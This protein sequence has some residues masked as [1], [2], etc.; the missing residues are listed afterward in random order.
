MSHDI[1]H[2][3]LTVPSSTPRLRPEGRK[4]KGQPANL[5]ASYPSWGRM[6]S[7]TCQTGFIDNKSLFSYRKN[8]GLII[9]RL[10]IAGDKG[11]RR[12]QVLFDTGASASFVRG[13][14]VDKLATTL[15]LP[16]PES[17]TLG[18]GV[19]KLRVNETVVLYVYIDG[20][21]ISD[22]F[23]AAP[24]RGS[25]YTNRSP[26]TAP[27]RTPRRRRTGPLADGL[28]RELSRTAR[29]ADIRP[30]DPLASIQTSPRSGHSP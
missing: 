1:H 18:D 29:T 27:G 4:I 15:K 23:I 13:D 2:T 21:R 6:S 22:N 9:K 7:R 3:S 17:Y 24:P 28:R 11:E 8:M 30:N 19:G 16:S 20:V 12:L 5:K 10:K 26:T 25:G 14:V